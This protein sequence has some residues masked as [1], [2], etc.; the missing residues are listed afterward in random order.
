MR[1]VTI[2]ACCAAL[3]PPPR[4]RTAP[5]RSAT[6]KNDHPTTT[7]PLYITPKGRVVAVG[8]VHG[9]VEA[10]GATLRAC[11]LVGEGGDWVGGDATL[12]QL[13]DVL[14]RG[15]AEA[16]CLALL[17]A[18][19]VSARRAGGAVVRLLGNHEVMNVCGIAANYVHP[20][21]RDAF[22]PDRDAAWAPGGALRRRATGPFFR[23]TGPFFRATGEL[24]RTEHEI[25][26]VST[27]RHF[28][29]VV[30][31]L[32]TALAD[33]CYA[34]AVVGD[35]CFVHAHLPAGATPESLAALNGA[36]RRWLRGEPC[37]ASDDDELCD[38]TADRVNAFVSQHA[39]PRAGAEAL[40]FPLS[41][42]ADRDLSPVW[43]RALSA[44]AGVPR[45]SSRDFDRGNDEQSSERL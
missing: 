33:D 12:V 9:D 34:A 17:D 15:D 10:L 37:D 7:A 4:R 3:A 14:G 16:A 36:A 6:A 38:L 43:G 23:A 25:H 19:A 45:R 21:A 29:S 18:L 30:G 44:L 24:F 13:G 41:P 32:A 11:G 31:A 8:D 28:D 35:T 1:L 20:A 39:P 42:H 40:P 27:R 26:S 5:P 2:I 22:G